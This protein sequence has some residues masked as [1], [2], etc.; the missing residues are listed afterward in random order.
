REPQGE[1]GRDLPPGRIAAPAPERR[2]DRGRRRDR[3]RGGLSGPR[4]RDRRARLHVAGMSEG[5]SAEPSSGFVRGLHGVRY[6]VSDVSRSVAFYTEHLGF[7]L[8]H[9]QLPAFA[10]VTL[11]GLSLLLSGPGA[12]G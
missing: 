9:Q 8:R 7:T 5:A 11:A 2:A 4:D 1:R 12:S 3:R 6:L 10:N